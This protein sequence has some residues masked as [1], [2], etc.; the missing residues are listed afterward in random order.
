MSPR[1][2]GDQQ[3]IN[4]S[5]LTDDVLGNS[6]LQPAAGILQTFSTSWKTL[7]CIHPDSIG[8]GQ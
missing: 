4:D 7:R 2:Q 8:S 3:F 1:Q 6:A 5:L